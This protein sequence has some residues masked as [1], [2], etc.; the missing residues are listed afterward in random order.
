MCI[1]D[2][3]RPSSLVISVDGRQRDAAIRDK[4]LEEVGLSQKDWNEVNQEKQGLE[5]DSSDKAN[6]WSISIWTNL[7]RDG[8]ARH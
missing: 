8:W 1:S 4:V 7:Q 2:T 6:L 3:D 5:L